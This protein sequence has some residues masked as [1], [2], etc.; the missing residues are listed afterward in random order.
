MLSI[1]ENLRFTGQVHHMTKIWVKKIGF[2]IQLHLNL[3]GVNFCVSMSWTYWGSVKYLSKFDVKG[4]SQYMTKYWPKSGKELISIK[5][6]D[7]NDCQLFEHLGEEPEGW[8]ILNER[9]LNWNYQ[10]S[11]NSSGQKK[12]FSFPYGKTWMHFE[13]PHTICSKTSFVEYLYG[14]ESV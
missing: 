11:I 7:W 8:K 5:R 13:H 3:P 4:Q 10:K 12:V 1:S 6:T 2:N 9:D 14:R